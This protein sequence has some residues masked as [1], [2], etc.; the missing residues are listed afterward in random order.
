MPKD[1][2]DEKGNIIGADNRDDFEKT[3]EQYLEKYPD[4][5][6]LIGPLLSA[7][8]NRDLA[9]KHVKHKKADNIAQRVNFTH[10]LRE[11]ANAF[12]LGY[13]CFDETIRDNAR[14]E[15][16]PKWITI[17]D[18]KTWILNG[19]DYKAKEDL[20]PE[21]ERK[22]VQTQTAI[23]LSVIIINKIKALDEFGNPPPFGD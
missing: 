23:V 5:I 20:I 19:I 8:Q 10:E 2:L 15:Q 13:Y 4:M 14:K 3:L 11:K 22:N 17:A 9:D 1:V 16:P 6:E 18:Y 7:R 12:F 21:E